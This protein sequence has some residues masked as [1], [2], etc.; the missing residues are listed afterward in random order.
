MYHQLVLIWVRDPAKFQEY[1]RRLP[2]IVAK[3]G[4]AGD[5]TIQPTS[6]WADGL[7]RPT[8]V[9]LVH[10]DDKESYQRFNADPDFLAI[11]HLRSESVDLMTFEGLLTH[12][13]PSDDGLADRSYNVELLRYASGSPEAYRRYEREGEAVMRRYGFRVEYVLEIEPSA[14]RRFDLAKI[15]Y[16]PNSAAQADFENDPLHKVIEEELYPAAVG[17]S[18]WI[19]GI[20]RT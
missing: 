3:Y 7:E 8:I 18:I 16:F 10:Y 14:A 6:I 15:S 9:N 5:R 1:L 12:S 17:D 19:T 4:G 20:A 11:E 13:G 2:P